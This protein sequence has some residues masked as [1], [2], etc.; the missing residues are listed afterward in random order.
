MSKI[1]QKSVCLCAN[2]SE[3]GFL[4]LSGDILPYLRTFPKGRIYGQSRPA[5]KHFSKAFISSGN[6]RELS[7]CSRLIPA[8]NHLSKSI[9]LDMFALEARYYLSQKK[10]VRCSYFLAVAAMTARTLVH[11]SIRICRIECVTL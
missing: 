3:K 5:G 9:N 10:F 4:D 8:K 7:A 6:G 11:R 1:T 2:F